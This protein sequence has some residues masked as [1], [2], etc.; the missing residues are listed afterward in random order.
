MAVQMCRSHVVDVMMPACACGWS[1]C[2]QQPVMSVASQLSAAGL[3]AELWRDLHWQFDP[4]K[5]RACAERPA[6]DALAILS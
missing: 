6:S 4:A 1:T 5:S 3:P 2:T